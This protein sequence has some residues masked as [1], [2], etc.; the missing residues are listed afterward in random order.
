VQLKLGTRHRNDS[1]HKEGWDIVESTGCSMQSEVEVKHK[2]QPC[3]D[4]GRVAS[5]C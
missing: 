3:S 4:S 1:L 5:Q 2:V